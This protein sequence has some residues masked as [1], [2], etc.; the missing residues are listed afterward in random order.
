MKEPK[1]EEI[2]EDLFENPS[3]AIAD[4]SD[5]LEEIQ[6]ACNVIFGRLLEPAEFADLISAPNH[7]ELTI[8]AQRNNPNIE[9]KLGYRLFNGTHD[10]ILYV[11]AETNKRIVQFDTIANQDTAPD[12]LETLLFARQVRSFRDF[13]MDE[14]RLYAEGHAGH[15]SINGYYVWARFGFVMFLTGFAPQLAAAGFAPAETTLEIFAQNNGDDW[16]YNNGSAREAVFYLEEGSDCRQA[17]Q[18]Y[19]DGL[20]GKGKIEWRKKHTKKRI[21]P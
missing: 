13:G 9:L 6:A 5:N 21:T 1:S 15:P 3:V 11:E 20:A 19:L 16:W 8:E 18:I 10:Y 7:S 2:P 12:G 17:L 14:I 4:Y